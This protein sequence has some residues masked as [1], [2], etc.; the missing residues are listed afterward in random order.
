MKELRRQ[1]YRDLK[2][3]ESDLN[4]REVAL[5]TEEPLASTEREKDSSLYL[6][7]DQ[8]FIKQG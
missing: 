4:K 6:V 2:V 8:G 7:F 3:I 5:G 1:R